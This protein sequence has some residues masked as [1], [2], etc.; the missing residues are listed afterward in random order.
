VKTVWRG[1]SGRRGHSGRITL[2]SAAFHVATGQ[3]APESVVGRAS[4][5]LADRLERMDPGDLE[6]IELPFT[7]GVRKAVVR[8]A[9][10]PSGANRR[11][12]ELSLATEKELMTDFATVPLL[13]PPAPP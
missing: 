10:S 5:E 4:K 8:S 9:P 1:R 2:S 7:I 3:I 13:S 6:P 12:V 11:Y